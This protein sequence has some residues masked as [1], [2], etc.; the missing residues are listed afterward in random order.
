MRVFRCI[1]L[2]LFLKLNPLAS[3]SEL[4][5]SGGLNLVQGDLGGSQFN[6]AYRFWDIDLPT[7]RPYFSA[8]YRIR[9]SQFSTFRYRLEVSYSFISSSDKFAG[10]PDIRKRD[11]SMEGS[12][13]DINTI[14]D[15]YP[16]EYSNLHLFIGVGF[17]NSTVNVLKGQTNN[18]YQHNESYLSIPIGGAI[19]V[20]YIKG[21]HCE[22]ELM[23]HG[24]NTDLYN[25]YTDL[26]SK[27]N[28]TYTYFG[29]KLL[30]D[31]G[32][33]NSNKKQN[34]AY[35]KYGKIYCPRF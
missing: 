28:D 32:G 6:G 4:G 12:N 31:I 19:S 35:R 16:F 5:I 9:K 30:K 22:I 29:I 15:F 24:I 23:L 2:F 3:Q 21:Y 1:I 34:K 18:N 33:L 11:V 13:F 25:G 10:N 7:L 27:S 20:G 14:V 26:N 17:G 8:S